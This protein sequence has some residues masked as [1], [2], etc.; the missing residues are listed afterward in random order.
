MRQNV[1]G[2]L[3]QWLAGGHP[4]LQQAVGLPGPPS[5]PFHSLPTIVSLPAPASDVV[6]VL[7]ANITQ[8]TATGKGCP[9]PHSP[10]GCHPGRAGV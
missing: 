1:C 9:N 4:I 7:A 3:A 2:H 6:V 8:E 10:G 5:F